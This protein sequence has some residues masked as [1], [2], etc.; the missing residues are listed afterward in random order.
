V[1]KPTFKH[2]DVI[3]KDLALIEMLK[4]SVVLDKPIYTGF[5]VLEASKLL[6]Y[7][8]HYN[9]MQKLFDRPGQLRLLFTDTGL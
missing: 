4:T 1:S 7:K 2:F 5:V 9:R 8:F 6:M 3:N